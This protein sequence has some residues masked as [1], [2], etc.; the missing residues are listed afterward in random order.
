[1]NTTLLKEAAACLDAC[2]A[3]RRSAPL[4]E[5]GPRPVP[6]LTPAS[7]EEGH[8]HCQAARPKAASP[9]ASL[10]EGVAEVVAETPGELPAQGLGPAPD[11]APAVGSGEPVEAS[12][13]MP[14][15]AE[16]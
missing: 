3:D 5:S 13:A 6:L 14:A 1:M 8:R 15:A 2:P 16:A 4:A 12:A 7:R 9:G 10:R 11:Q